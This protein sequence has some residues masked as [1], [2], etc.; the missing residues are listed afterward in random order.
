MTGH[1]LQVVIIDD[2]RRFALHVWRYLARS[3]GFGIGDVPSGHPDLADG[4]YWAL[5]TPARDAVVWWINVWRPECKAEAQPWFKHLKE[6]LETAGDQV[7]FLIDVRGMTAGANEFWQQA[8]GALD[9]LNVPLNLDT[10]WLVSSYGVGRRSWPID[11]KAP[12]LFPIRPKSAETLQLLSDRLWAQPRSASK[13]SRREFH[14]LVSGAGFEFKSQTEKPRPGFPPV[15]SE[16]T[17]ISP[18]GIPPTAELLR[19]AYLADAWTVLAKG[20]ATERKH[21]KSMTFPLP[22]LREDDWENEVYKSANE[23][24]LDDL[25]NGL[26]KV[27]LAEVWRTWRSDEAESSR[28]ASML[29]AEEKARASFRSS[30][31]GDDWGQMTQVLIAASL[32]WDAWLTTNYTRFVDR[33][34][35]L[36]DNAPSKAKRPW[37]ILSITAEAEQMIRRLFFENSPQRRNFWRPIFK[38]HGDLSHLSTMAIAGHDKGLFSPLTQRVES[39]HWMYEAA[40]KWIERVLPQ[41]SKGKAQKSVVFWHVVGHDLKDETLLQSMQKIVDATTRSVQHEFLLVQPGAEKALGPLKTRLEERGFGNMGHWYPMAYRA[42]EWVA[43]LAKILR[44]GGVMSSLF[45]D[46]NKVPAN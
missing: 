16:L 33:A 5:E 40:V 23:G 20:M 32:P 24:R 37:R 11:G 46:C 28:E 15:P 13:Q 25:W 39:L 18:L 17:R 19:R 27:L 36:L 26:L 9:A 14:I 31:L 3:V 38:L 21:P 8:F 2:R 10:V 1:P 44:E 34:V 35:A 42:D 22:Q 43:R 6:A 4:L 29:D 12:L 45:A 30:F 41:R 7:V